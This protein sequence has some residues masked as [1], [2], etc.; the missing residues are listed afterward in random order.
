MILQSLV[1]YYERLAEQGKVAR[2]G[3]CSAK[4][5]YA[6]DL[7][8]DGSV[9]RVLPLKT[10]VERGKKTVLIP[11]VKQVPAMVSRSSGVSANFLCDNSKYILGI[12]KDG[13]NEHTRECFK[14]ACEK[15]T[16]ILGDI[17]NETAEAI[18]AFFQHWNPEQAK[19]NPVI[20]EHWGEVTDGGNLL[21]M[22]KGKFAQEDEEI[23]KKWETCS[24]NMEGAVTG[25]C[26][27]TGEKA[28]I[29][30]IH[31]PIKGVAGA[32]SSGAAL[33]S[34]NAPAFESYGKEQSYNAPVGNYAMFAYTTALNYLLSNKDYVKTLGDTTVVFW[35]ED[36]SVECQ[37]LFLA[38]SE[39]TKDNQELVGGVFQN[40]QK[41]WAVDVEAV[42]KNVN[43]EQKFYI[44]GLSP[45]AARLA[46]RFFY[47]D[48]FGEILRHLKEHYDRME[49]V[50]PAKDELK[51]LGV[52]RVLQ[53]TANKK[54]RDK[55][56]QE[57]VAGRTFE[58]ILSGGRYPESLY[59]AV[60][61]RIRAE[62][63]DSD[64]HI[65]KITRGRA[66]IMKAYLIRNTNIFNGKEETMVSL[67]ETCNDIPYVLGREFAVLEA[68]Q[69]DA[70]PGINSTIKDR[71]FN[72]A[73]ATPAI[74]FPT[75]LRLKN[76]HTRK[77]SK[78]QEIYYEKQLADLQGRLPAKGYPKRLSSQEQGQFII[79]Y[80][81]Q[82]QKRYEKKE[83]Q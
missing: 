8:I 33:V 21:F 31:T 83:D 61:R 14:A 68:I 35:A 56:P 23:A 57:D 18:K 27:V 78:G 59:S 45:N 5:S 11:D 2:P 76:S 53:E 22:V 77:L 39:P 55:K 37:N 58:A 46:V 9:R 3:W 20:L 74:I 54:S 40:L 38:A 6:L 29:S 36:A 67:D 26:L 4:V 63:D 69:E 25:T 13:M 73:C 66:A 82:T 30:R 75:L 43:L 28:E 7:R 80:Y 15:H 52:W 34:F 50:R 70:N 71:Y 65:Y 79:G 32:Q 42:E 41:G 47:A 24:L 17:K 60:M 44:L 81:H 72:S 49:I 19:E 1:Q 16:E 62:Q 48:Q 64:A 10:E 12:D 51:Y